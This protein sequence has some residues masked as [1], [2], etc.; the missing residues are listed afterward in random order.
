MGR[1]FRELGKGVNDQGMPL[2]HLTL[3]NMPL[4]AGPGRTFASPKPRPRPREAPAIIFIDELDAIGQKR[5]GGGE[6]SG[7]DLW[8]RRKVRAAKGSRESIRLDIWLWGLTCGVRAG[9]GGRPWSCSGLFQGIFCFG[10]G[11]NV[12]HIP[13]ESSAPKCPKTFSIAGIPVLPSLG[14]FGFKPVPT[15]CFWLFAWVTPRFVWVIEPW[16]SKNQCL[17]GLYSLESLQHIVLIDSKTRS[18]ELF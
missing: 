3:P 10:F 1:W 14:V 11:S 4:A 17:N 5:S 2:V 7:S 13:L 12:S 9:R 16:D 8:G 6:L 15:I 18:T